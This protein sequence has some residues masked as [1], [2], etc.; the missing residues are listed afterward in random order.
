MYEFIMLK[1]ADLEKIP[2]TDRADYVA[3]GNRIVVLTEEVNRLRRV[4]YGSKTE[5]HEVGELIHPK[6]TLFNEAE[7]IIQGE[8]DPVPAEADSSKNPRKRSPEAG[9]RKPFPENLPRRQIICDLTEAEKICPHDGTTLVKIDERI[10]ETIEVIPAKVTVIQHVYPKY[11]CPQC[12]QHMNE[13]PAEPSAIPQASCDASTLAHII[14]QKFLYGLPLYR[15]EQQFAQMGVEVSRTNLARWVI[16]SADLL[17]DVA[18]EIHKYI[19]AQPAVHADETHSSAPP[20][21][22]LKEQGK[23]QNQNR[24]CGVLVR[25]KTQNLP[26]GLNFHPIETRLLHQIYLENS[27]VFCMSMVMKVTVPQLLPTA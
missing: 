12:K 8:E 17:G 14:S 1:E 18:H 13:H 26:F 19:F 23:A 16:A 4:V 15:I 20:Y 25:A 5:F 9:G 21:K 7:E 6:G 3:L 11:G 22:F 24:T 2:L 27:T 10:V